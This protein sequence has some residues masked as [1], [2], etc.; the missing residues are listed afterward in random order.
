MK[1]DITLDYAKGLAIL[2]MMIGHCYSTENGILTLIYSFHMPCFFIISGIIY[3]KKLHFSGGGVQR[4]KPLKTIIHLMIPYFVFES[5][6]ALLL[7]ILNP[8]GDLLATLGAHLAS[9]V[10]CKGVTA[11]WYLSC[12]VF[13]E[14]AFMLL[15]RYLRGWGIAVA[16]LLFVAGM[17]V[18]VLQPGTMVVPVRCAIGMGFFGM[19]FF[20][21][22]KIGAEQK[23]CRLW[24]VGIL[25]AVFAASALRNGMVS[26]VSLRLENP[27]LYVISSLCGTMLLLWIAQVLC[28]SKMREPLRILKFLGE[29]TLFILCTHMFLVE[30]IRLADYKLLGNFFPRLGL[31]EGITFGLVLCGI[32]CVM[33]LCW[34]QGKRLWIERD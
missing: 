23:E 19:G 22:E 11:T 34:Q 24:A 8:Q 3:G 17:A 26:L 29:N 2:L 7:A 27:V 21:G 18:A 13:V 32:E 16:E 9:V 1:R 12:I 14:L 28:T 25:V 6:F 31:A 15:Y 4:F 10:T 20:Y 30:I 5:A 33:L